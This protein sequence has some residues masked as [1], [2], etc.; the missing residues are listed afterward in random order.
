MNIWRKKQK[1]KRQNMTAGARADIITDAGFIEGD[2]RA[3]NSLL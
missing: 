1:Q 2:R 3:E